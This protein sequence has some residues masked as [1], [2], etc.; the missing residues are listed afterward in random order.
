MYRL[1]E[2]PLANRDERVQLLGSGTI[3]REMLAAA[4]IL[5]NDH[6]MAADVWSVTSWTELRW[7]GLLAGDPSPAVRE[8]RNAVKPERSWVADCLAPTMGPIVAASDYVSAVAD[9]I[10]P[11]VPTGRR[12]VAL[13]TDGF[14][15]SDTRKNLRRFFGVDAA[16]IVAAARGNVQAA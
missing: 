10:R 2:S 1:R 16:S 12:Y 11:W 4:E 15:R 7:D 13:G 3:L 8:A 14:G 5:E 6:G 9:L